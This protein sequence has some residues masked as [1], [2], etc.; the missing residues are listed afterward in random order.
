M[1]PLAIRRLAWGPR[2]L[3][4]ASSAH[5]F[6]IALA[7][8]DWMPLT[9][10]VCP[11]LPPLVLVAAHMLADARGALF[12]R[13]RLAL[14]CAGQ[15]TAFALKGPSAARVIGDRF[16]L[17]EASRPVLAPASRVAT[18]DVGWVGAACDADIV[19]LAG[20]TD[21]EVAALPGGHTT[22]AISGAFLTGRSPDLL[23][24]QLA[25]PYGPS[26]PGPRFA[27]AVEANLA[28]DPLVAK[29]YRIVWRSPDTL[30]IRYAILSSAAGKS[31]E[32]DALP[33][34]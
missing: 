17:I 28:G 26:D 32:M 31:P 25:P 6:A 10:L 33:G 30:P 21:A 22:K 24:F 5:L 18:V 29:T 13:A 20:A 8:G 19:D 27:R 16:A 1:G 11:V 15:I 2:V 7:G 34:D 3:V 4:V 12:S 9:R 23:V 14:G